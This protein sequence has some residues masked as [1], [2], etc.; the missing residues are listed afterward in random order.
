[1]T[2]TSWST[3]QSFFDALHAEF[4]FTLDV[5]ALPSTAKCQRY[6]TP[7]VDG[8][9]QSWVGETFWMNPPYGRGQ[10][11]YAWVEKAY[12][13]T[14]KSG[15]GVCLLPASLDTRWFHQFVMRAADWRIVADRLWFELDG[16]AARANHAS[17]VA[18][19]KPGTHHR[20]VPRSIPNYRIVNQQR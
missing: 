7:E 8:L 13:D 14:R 18:V 2:V 17:M 10:N 9:K 19:F 16:V 5:C 20:P 15:T 12:Q 3:P 1:M 11:V 4:N 6:F